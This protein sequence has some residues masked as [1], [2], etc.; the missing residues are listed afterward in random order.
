[1]SAPESLP[2]GGHERRD[3]RVGTV[4]G[5]SVG[6]VG[7]VVFTVVTMWLLVQGLRSRQ[8]H[9]SPPASPLAGSYGPSEPPAPRLQTD[10]RGDIAGLRAREQAQ[11]DGYGWI[12]RG[13]GTVHIPI[14]RAMELFV[15]RR[16]SER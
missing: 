13:A 11:L 3:I 9:L 14:D 16:G 7:L 1:M 5:W 8:E 6:L 4:L 12:D 15:Q 2:D 10:P